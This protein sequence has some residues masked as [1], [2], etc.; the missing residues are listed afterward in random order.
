MDTSVK[1]ALTNGALL[2]VFYQPFLD[3][4][5]LE[6]AT[7]VPRYLGSAETRDEDP[8]RWSA[9]MPM[10]VE[11]LWSSLQDL[12]EQVQRS[13][14]KASNPADA[15]LVQGCM[16]LLS[17]MRQETLQVDQG[18]AMLFIQRLLGISNEHA[19][20]TVTFPHGASVKEQVQNAWNS[21]NYQEALDLYFETLIHE[22]LDAEKQQQRTA[23]VGN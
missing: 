13:P 7:V 2:R 18:L 6:Q 9:E 14:E 20:Y 22:S 5:R 23:V 16:H 8:W 10:Q 12:R 1:S 19:R 17:I 15:K 4:T 11:K 3:L 21:G